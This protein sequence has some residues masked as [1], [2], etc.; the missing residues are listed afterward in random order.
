[1]RYSK[2]YID[3]HGYNRYE[4]IIDHGISGGIDEKMGYIT[5]AEA[6]AQCK[7][8]IKEQ[9]ADG[10]AIF[11]FVRNK[12]VATFNGFSQRHFAEEYRNENAKVYWID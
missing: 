2:E 11:D 3:R 7:Y 9:E 10:A 8:Y 5:L 1:M 6:K 12:V 4:V